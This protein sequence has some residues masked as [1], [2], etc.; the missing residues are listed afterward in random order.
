MTLSPG[1]SAAPPLPAGI[2]A[3]TSVEGIQE[4]RLANGLRLLLFPDP[5][6]P[7]TTVNVTYLVGSRHE[8]YG[9]SGMAH[10][11]E[12]LVFKGTPR[13]PDI[14]QELTARG[15][16]PNGSTWVDRTN[17]FETFPASPENLEWALDL[18][19]DRMVSSFIAQEHLDSEMT[20]VRN[21]FEIG[22]NDPHGVLME[23]VFSTAYLWHNYGRSTIGARSDIERVPIG[24]LQAFYRRWYQPDNAVLVVAGRFD[25]HHALESVARTFGAI[26]RPERQLPETWTEE[27][28][29]DGERTVTLHRAGEVQLAAAAF[30]VPA[31]AHPDFAAVD[32]LAHVLGDTPAGRLHRRLVERRLASSAG[33]W[34]FQF[35]DPSLLYL[36]AEVRRGQ[37]LAEARDAM[38]AELDG[39]AGDE[40]PAEVEVERARAARLK[41]WDATMRNSER[42]AL[43]LSEWAAMGDWRLMFLHR[44]RLQ[45]ATV[46]DVQ[47][48]AALYL[49][50]ENRTVGLFVPTDGPRRAAVPPAPDLA[51]MV[52]GYRGDP[53]FAAG[54]PF[55]PAPAAIEARLERFTL[56]AGT[57]VVLL[58]KRTRGG[59]VQLA[60]TFRFGDEASLA[61]R[62]LD[63][64]LA[65]AMLTRGSRRRDRQA[66]QD[67]LDRLR[68]QLRLGGGADAVQAT[69]EV[70][71]G[72]LPAALALLAELLREPAFP[73]R[74][75]ELL[76]E[77]HLAS[78]AEAGRDPQQVA[79]TAFRRRLAAFP[80]GD[81]RHV[82]L[83][84]A[85]IA[86]LAEVRAERLRELWEGQAG[87]STGEIAVVGDFDPV[88]LRALLGELFGSWR[89]PR[90]FARLATP[91]R[92][93]DAGEEVFPIT[94]KESAVHVAGAAFPLR[95]DDAD[96]APFVLGNF[97]TGGGFLNSRLATRLRQKEGFSYGTGSSF[98]ASAFEP[99]AVFLA[100]AFYAPQNHER[101]AAAMA[102]ELERILADG[103]A[104]DEVAVA[105]QGWLQ[106]R[107]LARGND[108][109]LARA[110][111]QREFQGRT[112]AWDAA[113]EARAAA[114]DGEAILAAMRRQLR[115]D[116]LVLVRA[117]NFASAAAASAS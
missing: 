45:A 37:S 117:G 79:F 70:G 33:A 104:E 81:P 115:L 52:A 85:K 60:A 56:D 84:Q 40:P 88:A 109:E 20:V 23:R 98:R 36:V 54:E 87:A 80:E 25:E 105:R 63:G 13:H 15:A 32:L 51:T 72:E 102:E 11:L 62:G 100:Y 2:E 116:R 68:A 53:G 78:L 41:A 108:R 44:D 5:S 106:G 69:L 89:S 29:Q 73:E 97:M 39:L 64:E 91:F 50:T 43:R 90:P 1:S 67:E 110:L 58:P 4:L 16:R 99:D 6:K 112:L 46:E 38:L 19:A 103:F 94:D 28:A 96:F 24:N 18:E 22:E 9:E 57:R 86:A 30:H 65:A 74:E 14:P 34:A 77:E 48:V 107:D 82:W 76:R 42:A 92:P 21:E 66:I 27:P 55:D 47:R 101:L 31:G 10:L 113:L 7:T 61:G 59:T 111:A 3:V 95:E 114:L 49:A 12:H 35:R 71:R 17:Y 83:P 8:G 93:Y 75:L 26:P